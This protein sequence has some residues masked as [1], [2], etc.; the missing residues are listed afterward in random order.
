MEVNPDISLWTDVERFRIHLKS[1]LLLNG[2]HLDDFIVKKDVIY[3]ICSNDNRD[4]SF[5][6]RIDQ[7]KTFSEGAD[8]IVKNMLEAFENMPDN[9]VGEIG[10]G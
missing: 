9:V 1:E 7:E 8:I 3:G 6:I 4:F 5:G 10:Q 2:I